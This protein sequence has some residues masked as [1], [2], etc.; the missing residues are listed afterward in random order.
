MSLTSLGLSMNF[1]LANTVVQE[2]APDYLR[3]RVSAVFGLSFFG[4]MP[5]A[6]LVLTSVSDLIGMQNAMLL[7][8]IVYGT[9]G[10]IVL[11]RVRGQCR[12]QATVVPAEPTVPVA[13]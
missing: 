7:G 11:S 3:G 10:I 6:G 4:L 13:A 9:L 1:G 2:R 8:S 12:G 5:I